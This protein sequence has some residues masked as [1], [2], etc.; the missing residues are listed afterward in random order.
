[1]WICLAEV[2]DEKKKEVPD[3]L[4]RL[5]QGRRERNGLTFSFSFLPIS[6]SSGCHSK[7]QTGWLTQQMSV[8]SQS[9]R[10]YVQ[11]HMAFPLCVHWERE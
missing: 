8:L 7:T 1:M 3:E 6:V 9:W 4:E 5:S 2:P 10:L 11:D